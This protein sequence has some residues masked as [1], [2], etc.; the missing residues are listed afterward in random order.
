M[1]YYGQT[2]SI[3]VSPGA[4][5]SGLEAHTARQFRSMA[6]DYYAATGNAITVDSGYRSLA[7][8]AALYAANP[9]TAAA[10]GRSMHNYGYAIDIL[11]TDA[12][13]LDAG[14]YLAKYGFWRPLMA[15]GVT[16][17]ESWH[18]EQKG[19][20]YEAIRSAGYDAVAVAAADAAVGAVWLFPLA[21][22]VTIGYLVYKGRK[23]AS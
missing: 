8:Q 6:D 4:D 17:K 3:T 11:S 22:A 7:E 5:I 10:P 15:A 12:D 20:D 19:L 13:A 9:L 14:G 1:E 18:L 16:H 21:V 2:D 23:R